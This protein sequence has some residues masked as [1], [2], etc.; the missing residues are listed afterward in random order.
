MF[1]FEL[2]VN[3]DTRLRC[4]TEYSA[5]CEGPRFDLAALANA[6]IWT[7]LRLLVMVWQGDATR[8]A[9]AVSVPG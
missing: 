7:L 5:Q 6:E 4:R 1:P 2:L 3:L 9:N 8:F